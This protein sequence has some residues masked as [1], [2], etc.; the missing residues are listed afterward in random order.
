[1]SL[2]SALEDSQLSNRG[3]GHGFNVPDRSN[4]A[5]RIHILYHRVVLVKGRLS[6][7]RHTLDMRIQQRLPDLQV[8]IPR[9]QTC[10][11][12]QY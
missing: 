11:E 1:M 10:R 2:T 9:E 12:C 5:L 3:F 7:E 4:R 8:R 6:V